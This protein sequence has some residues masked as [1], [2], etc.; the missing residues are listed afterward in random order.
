MSQ[1]SN[2]VAKVAL[3][4]AITGGVLALLVVATI[5]SAQWRHGDESTVAA[6]LIGAS[7]A[8]IVSLASAGTATK[9]RG[10]GSVASWLSLL[11]AASACAMT[12]WTWGIL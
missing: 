3:G 11:L 2:D 12:W 7:V 10:I 6:L 4:A 5:R 1:S 8:S 9:I